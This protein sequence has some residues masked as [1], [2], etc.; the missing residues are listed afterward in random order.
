MSPALSPFQHKSQDP[1]ARLV[2]VEDDENVRRS[3]MMSLRAR[4]FYVDTYRSGPEFLTMNGRHDGDCLLID[5]KMPRI[6]GLELIR[7][8]RKQNDHTPAI[9]ITGFFSDSLKDRAISAGFSNVL[10]KPS[11]PSALE[12]MIHSLLK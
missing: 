8:I 7:R 1:P 4:G 5:Y 12:V 11:T 2:L 10:E 6:D 3:M 9:M